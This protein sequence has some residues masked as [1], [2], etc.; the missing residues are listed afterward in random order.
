MTQ[1][2][3]P[4]KPAILSRADIAM[5]KG[6][7]EEV[8]GYISHLE[9]AVVRPITNARILLSYAIACD[10]AP[11]QRQAINDNVGPRYRDLQ[12]NPFDGAKG[13]N[14]YAQQLVA[15]LVKAGIGDGPAHEV[16]ENC[17]VAVQTALRKSLSQGQAPSR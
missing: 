6:F 9:T 14:Y 13:T 3:I 5:M 15:C 11:M 4:E 10:M 7:D 8:N 17:T 1:S 16:V 12:G 2:V